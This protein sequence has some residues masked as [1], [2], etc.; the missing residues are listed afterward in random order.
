MLLMG[1]YARTSP[2]QVA[3]CPL[4]ATAAPAS[5]PPPL[6]ITVPSE[7]SAEKTLL[8]A[9][10]PV[11]VYT[12]SKNETKTKPLMI[13]RFD[14]RGNCMQIKD[15]EEIYFFPDGCIVFGSTV[16]D[17]Q[18]FKRQYARTKAQELGWKMEEAEAARRF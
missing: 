6:V 11:D 9:S 14:R 18:R 13:V 4:L 3:P 16:H 10:A 7:G 2:P 17:R 8:I 12:V 5:R 1:G 15:R